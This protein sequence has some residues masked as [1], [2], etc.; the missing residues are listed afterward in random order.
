MNNS[1][2]SYDNYAQPGIQAQVPYPA[3]AAVPVPMPSAS[4]GPPMA[5]E[6]EIVDLRKG[7]LI[8]G[9]A[10]IGGIVGTLGILMYTAYENDKDHAKFNGEIEDL[11]DETLRLKENLDKYTANL[12][13]GVR[14]A[15][16]LAAD[17][18]LMGDETK[19]MS[20]RPQTRYQEPY[21]RDTMS[22]VYAAPTVPISEP[23]ASMRYFPA[24]ETTLVG[25]RPSL[26]GPSV[27]VTEP[28]T[29]FYPSALESAIESITLARQSPSSRPTLPRSSRAATRRRVG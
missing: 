13:R 26:A 19:L 11:F 8:M 12:E 9:I 25:L 22:A 29:Q 1:P 23:R 24:E 4:P 28:A 27:R 7:S 10:V 14:F 20:M 6:A 5:T 15:A 3:P 2:Y 21:F 16:G 18:V 17:A